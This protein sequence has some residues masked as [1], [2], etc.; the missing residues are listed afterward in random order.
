MKTDFLKLNSSQKIYFACTV[1]GIFIGLCTC[2]FSYIL[3]MGMEYSGG[4]SGLENHGIH[5]YLSD[6]SSHYRQWFLP[7]F[8][9]IGGLI[10]FGLAWFYPRILKMGTNNV[11]DA[12]H[13]HEGKNDIKETP[14]LAAST[15]AALSCGAS[16]GKEGPVAAMGSSVGSWLGDYLGLGARARR[17]FLLAGAAGALGAIFHAPLGGALLAIEVLYRDDFETD[18][19]IP[20]FISSISAFFIVRIIL[21]DHHRIIQTNIEMMKIFDNR[22]IIIYFILGI[23]CAFGGKFFLFIKDKIEELF[24]KLP[25]SH[26]FHPLIGAGLLALIGYFFPVVMGTG[27]DKMNMLANGT[28]TEYQKLIALL[29]LFFVMKAIATSICFGSGFT[30]GLFGPAFVLGGIIGAIVGYSAQYFFPESVA[31]P[32]PYII[33]GMATFF[34]GVSHAPLASLMMATELSGFSYELLP[35]II[36][37]I[38]IVT[39]LN[40]RQTLY[41]AQVENKFFSPAHLWD[42]KIN[43]LNTIRVRECEDKFGHDAVVQEYMNVEKF[44][45][46]SKETHT[47]DFIVTS[48]KN[49]YRGVISM[50]HTDIDPMISSLIVLHDIM[51]ESV[52]SCTLDENLTDVLEKL[53]K[54]DMDKLAIVDDKKQLLGYIRYR[55]ILNIYMKEV[56]R[57]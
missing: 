19:L 50:R 1:M 18:S 10:V 33:I 54:T 16:A 7:L 24:S 49:E 21:P 51:D 29:L 55:D 23:A 13:N 15:I 40:Q 37:A 46:H 36:V 4:L 26:K 32:L 52:P 3:H 53:L 22:E 9:I 57:D 39:I 41:R 31:S 35:A 34:T 6:R 12:F 27:F 56:R 11:I 14:A 25:L 42:M 8:P 45:K 30:G 48:K 5:D 47:S 44:E 43:V 2:V 38:A 17:T 28:V 20:C